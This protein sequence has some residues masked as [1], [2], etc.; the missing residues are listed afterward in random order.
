MKELKE[1]IDALEGL[2]HLY[3]HLDDL[4]PSRPVGEQLLDL[5]EDLF[6]AQFHDG[7]IVD[8]GFYPWSPDGVFRILVIRDED[9]DCP[10]RQ[11]ECK[12]LSDLFKLLKETLLHINTL[13]KRKENR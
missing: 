9:W 13:S 10:V 1:C 6:Q 3:N 7:L 11:V 8:V 12:E 4:D 2:T 5:D